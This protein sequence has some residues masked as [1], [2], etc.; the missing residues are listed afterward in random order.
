MYPSD[1][2]INGQL[3]QGQGKAEA[4]INPAT[5]ATFCTGNEAS[6]EQVEAAVQ[7]AEQPCLRATLATN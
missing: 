2:L 6:A 4:I 3:V 7:A 5:G 1:L